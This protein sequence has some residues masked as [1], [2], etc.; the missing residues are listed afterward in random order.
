[1]SSDV[2][3][4][5]S[6]CL[7]V[8][9]TAPGMAEMKAMLRSL[10]ERGFAAIRNSEDVGALMLCDLDLCTI[11]SKSSFAEGVPSEVWLITE[12]AVVP[13]SQSVRMAIADALWDAE[14]APAAAAPAP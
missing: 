6:K 3:G 5:V 11:V 14:Q 2:F 9:E 10:A 4:G 12:F 1:M 7:R 13:T 8:D